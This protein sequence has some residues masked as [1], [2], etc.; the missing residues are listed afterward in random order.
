MYKGVTLGN[1]YDNFFADEIH[2]KDLL[3]E[4]TQ[5]KSKEHKVDLMVAARQTL[6]S[7]LDEIDRRERLVVERAMKDRASLLAELDRKKRDEEQQMAREHDAEHRLQKEKSAPEPNRSHERKQQQQQEVAKRTG[8]R[9][10]AGAMLFVHQQSLQDS[11]AADSVAQSSQSS[12]PPLSPRRPTRT[13]IQKKTAR[14]R[15]Q[16][17][18]YYPIHSLMV[19]SITKIYYF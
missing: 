1:F 15:A 18:F 4:D 16:V 17:S 19:T 11:A 13:K 8:G 3:D 2:G 9:L 5:A 12:Q 6:G 14:S 10:F 7:K